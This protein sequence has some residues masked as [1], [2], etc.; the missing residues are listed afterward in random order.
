MARRLK[1]VGAQIG[2]RLDTAPIPGSPNRISAQQLRE[3]A[4]EYLRD[5]DEELAGFQELAG[6]PHWNLWM[7][8]ARYQDALFAVLIFRDDGME[9]FCGTGNAYEVKQF[10]ERGFPDNSDDVL[11]MKT[12]RFSIPGGSVRIDRPVAEEWLGRGW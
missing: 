4:G 5:H 2:L 7:M 1:A 10:A 12:A 3:W 11:G 6:Q 8:D 9:F